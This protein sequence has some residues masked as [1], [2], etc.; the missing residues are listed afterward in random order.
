MSKQPLPLIMGRGAYGNP[1]NR[2]TG[3]V[4]EDDPD[5]LDPDEEAVQGKRRVPTR[6]FRDEARTIISQND[7]PDIPFRYSL[8]VYRGCVHGCS[9][10]FARPTHEY[11]ELGAGLDFETHIFVKERAPEL[12]RDWLAR[13]GYE[14]ETI[15]MS[16]VSDCYQ[17]IERDLALA[18]RCL[19]V[20]WEARQ[21]LAVVTKNALVT[22]D[23]D[24]LAAM[25]RE[26]TVSVAIS[27]T[28]LDQ[29]LAKVM[30]PRTSS[31]A[32]RLRAIH[33]LAAAG[34]PTT[35]L[36]APVIP[37]LTEHEMP[38][39]LRAAQEA[40]ATGAGYI[41]LRLPLTVEPVFLDW[42]ART[43]PTR[44]AKVLER[45]RA[46]RGGKLYES[47]FGVRM[48]GRGPIADQ[49]RQTFN[50]FARRLGL[51]GDRAPLDATKFRRP[52]TSS[53][54]GWLF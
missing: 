17:P 52:T 21:P 30:E 15:M 50:V 24:L 40:G 10:C 4:Y 51:H 33:Q 49:I 20:A 34:V 2:F 8:N 26:G 23:L 29:G 46:T 25:A 16:A 12:F 42:L 6:Y 36:I 11:F 48:K 9:Y 47:T 27:I 31:P 45:V 28:T 39:I 7:S 3:L 37:G 43:Q 1:A 54:Q 14:P 32:A 53:G 35:V 38:A 5:S 22:R 44:Q 13:D 18:R 19:E 41:L